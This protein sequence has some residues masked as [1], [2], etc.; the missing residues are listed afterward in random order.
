[1]DE[2]IYFSNL[3][4]YDANTADNESSTSV[5]AVDT[6]YVPLD[7]NYKSCKSILGNDP[8]KSKDMLHKSKPIT[9]RVSYWSY[10]TVVRMILEPN[11]SQDHTTLYSNIKRGNFHSRLIAFVKLAE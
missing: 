1:M 10:Y 2:K 7:E 3:E 4:C 11:M 6:K 9:V 5:A 8:L